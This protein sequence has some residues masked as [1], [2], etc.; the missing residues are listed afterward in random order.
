MAD[1]DEQGTAAEE[2]PLDDA[3]SIQD[4][5]ANGEHEQDPEPPEPPMEGEVQLSMNI[6]GIVSNR[7]ARKVEEA[8]LRLLGGKRPIGGLLDID[9]EYDLIVRVLPDPPTPKANRDSATR[10]TQ[11]FDLDQQAQV[12][13][14]RRADE[15]AIG[16]L[17]AGL[18][19]RDQAAAGRLL[20]AMTAAFKDGE[21]AGLR[22][23][24]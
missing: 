19:D 12:L 5:A 18:L 15:E 10:K 17:F 3:A 22:A 1:E 4:R 11:S 20:E 16:D 21:G 14:I 7:N 9:T 2:R 8:T 6:G 13:H 24:A 23:A